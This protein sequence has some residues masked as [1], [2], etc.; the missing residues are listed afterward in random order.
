MGL[1]KEEKERRKAEY[2]KSKEFDND[3]DNLNKTLD[4]L[5]REVK[6]QKKRSD[7]NLER[8]KKIGLLARKPKSNKGGKAKKVTKTKVIKAKKTTK[9]KKAK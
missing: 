2:R 1:D 4:N 9:H 6:E 8:Y 7:E 5:S 3:L